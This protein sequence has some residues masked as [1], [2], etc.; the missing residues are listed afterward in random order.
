MITIF[1]AD[2]CEYCNRAKDLATQYNLPVTYLSVDMAAHKK[3]LVMRMSDLPT[4]VWN[5][6]SRLTI[7]QIWWDG[8][9]IGG[10]DKFAAEVENTLG[11]YGQGPC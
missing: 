4:D 3:D 7:P 6:N 10:F 11:N 8:R 9:Y 2:W 5:S 1:G